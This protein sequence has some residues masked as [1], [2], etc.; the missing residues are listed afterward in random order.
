MACRQEHDRCHAITHLYAPSFSVNRIHTLAWP[1]DCRSPVA[2]SVN[3]GLSASVVLFSLSDKPVQ[4]RIA[5]NT[6]VQ[7]GVCLSYGGN[8]APA[9]HRF[10]S[11]AASG[12]S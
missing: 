5:H 12:Q 3:V 6:V 9:L 2:P 1:W 7:V 8:Q 10:S 4:Y 11:S